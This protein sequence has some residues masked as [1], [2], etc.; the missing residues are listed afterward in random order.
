LHDP[1]PRLAQSLANRR[2]PLRISVTAQHARAAP[3][4]I[5]HGQGPNDLP[6]EQIIGIW[7]G[8]DD[9]DAA[10]RE[11]NDEECLI[12]HQALPRPDLRGEEIRARDRALMRAEKCLP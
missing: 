10:R 2:T 4:P 9:L 6:H 3:H 7:R 8:P 1:G 5:S 11:V 12:R